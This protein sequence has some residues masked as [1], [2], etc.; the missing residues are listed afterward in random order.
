ML[1]RSGGTLLAVRSE[2]G[3]PIRWIGVGEG[4]SDLEPFDARAFATRLVEA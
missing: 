4:V 1:F 2:L 3:V